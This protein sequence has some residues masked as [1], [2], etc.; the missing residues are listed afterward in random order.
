MSKFAS[1]RL[2]LP[3]LVLGALGF[4]PRGPLAGWTYHL[5]LEKKLVWPQCPYRFAGY[6][7][8]ESVEQ[9]DKVGPK[10][11][12]NLEASGVSGWFYVRMRCTFE[13]E[14][15]TEYENVS[16]MPPLSREEI[17]YLGFSRDCGTSEV[18]GRDLDKLNSDLFQFRFILQDDFGFAVEARGRAECSDRFLGAPE[19]CYNDYVEMQAKPVRWWLH[20]AAAPSGLVRFPNTKAGCADPFSWRAKD[21]VYQLTCT[22]G[23]FSLFEADDV[24][25]QTVFCPAGT[26]LGDSEKPTWAD[27][28][29][30][31]WA[32][33]NVESPTGAVNIA[34][35]C[36]KHPVELK[37]RV[38]FVVN[39][40]GPFSGRW[41]QFSEQYLDL[42]NEEGGEIDAHIFVEEGGN[43]SYILWKSDDNNVGLPTTRIWIQKCGL[44]KHGINLVGDRH[45]LMNSSGLW[46][47]D[48]FVEGGSLVEG[49][50]LHRRGDY[51]YLFF[52][53]GKF[54]QDSYSEGVARSKDIMGP[55]TKLPVPLLTTA[56]VGDVVLPDPDGVSKI[57]GPGH[58]SFVKSRDGTELYA[59][60]HGTPAGKC[61]RRAFV[62][63]V[64][65]TKDGWPYIDFDNFC[66]R[67]QSAAT[68]EEQ[69]SVIREKAVQFLK[70]TAEWQDVQ[71]K[72]K[73]EK[74]T[75]TARAEREA[76][77]HYVVKNKDTEEGSYTPEDP[78]DDPMEIPY[79]PNSR[80]K[81]HRRRYKQKAHVKNSDHKR[82]VHTE[83]VNVA[84]RVHKTTKPPHYLH[85]YRE[86]EED[87]DTSSED[88]FT[89]SPSVMHR[90]TL[91][92]E[93]R[94]IDH[95]QA[96]NT[97]IRHDNKRY[98][99]KEAEPVARHPVRYHHSSS[100]FH[101]GGRN[102]Y[103][104][105]DASLYQ[106][107]SEDQRARRGTDEDSK[108]YHNERRRHRIDAHR[109]GGG[110]STTEEST[111]AEDS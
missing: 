86:E 16:D 105:A 54:C 28:E 29:E 83:D 75:D 59:V 109:T 70:D 7:T 85:E 17:Q 60:W 76:F 64:A 32:P 66:E 3:T 71:C 39:T 44:S 27:N 77:T 68:D 102:Q 84:Y 56:M 55:Y 36:N 23:N 87:D 80:M 52:A 81:L 78:T 43:L 1:Q 96:R 9:H 79:N 40:R 18:G 26:L 21:G 5:E 110:R 50:E 104:F 11:V 97:V 35:F 107:S 94:R 108:N 31:R 93:H 101:H 99:N 38:G 4:S 42:G 20:V 72:N 103:Q 63:R 41:S 53:S 10:S 25:P 90:P 47:S 92:Q 46:W 57:I 100:H 37:Q 45:E 69:A 111:E 12:F 48:S 82:S 14:G 19:S 15:A 13:D 30:N 24:G 88:Y 65:W 22:G 67:H 49:P 106:M 62:D 98:V 58:A 91:S 6:S 34:V 89:S 33:E 73:R 8:C 61:E 74:A 2:L 95:S 51:Y